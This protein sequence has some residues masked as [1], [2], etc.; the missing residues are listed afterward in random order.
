MPSRI[1][2]LNIQGIPGGAAA[3]WALPASLLDESIPLPVE[4]ENQ[5][6]SRYEG[7]VLPINLQSVSV[8]MILSAMIKAIASPAEYGLE[9]SRLEYYRNLVLALKPEIF[10]ELNSAA[11]VKARNGDFD[12]ALEIT[13]LLEGLFPGAPLLLINK[14]LIL[15]DK[16]ESY[17]AGRAGNGLDA[18]ELNAKILELYEKLLANKPMLPEALLNA[19]F[20]FLRRK[21]YRRARECFS[22]YLS[23][24]EDEP[25]N[26]GK[27]KKVLAIVKD[28]EKRGLDDRDF[29]EAFELVRTG[30][31]GEGLLRIKAFL[32]RRPT[33]WNGWFVLG[34]ALRILGRWQDS[35]EAYKKAV[36]FGG[37]NS[38]THNE[39]AICYMELG[40][41]PAARKELESALKDDPENT[42]TISNL[43]VTASKS[44][45]KELAAAYFRTVLELDPDDIIAQNYFKRA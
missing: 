40:D 43:G 4:F 25:E 45:N 5:E 18:S 23:V 28:I 22:D 6:K 27:R 2:F 34:W 24:T 26:E 20:F 35:I 41:L 14:A 16:A 32:E 42:K 30:N 37:K 39:A 44:G 21:E 13:A 17:A 1:A 12:M 8:E 38:D 29:M 36:E 10:N 3:R 33:A 9:Q 19:G 7:N 31:A 15:E 11:I